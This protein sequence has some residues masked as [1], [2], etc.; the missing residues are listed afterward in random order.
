M[1]YFFRIYRSIYDI[2]YILEYR[3]NLHNLNIMTCYLTYG[4]FFLNLYA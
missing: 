1:L 2:P 4:F 3:L